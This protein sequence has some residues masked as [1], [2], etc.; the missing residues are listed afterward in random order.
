MS[1]LQNRRPQN[2]KWNAKIFLAEKICLLW[3]R[4]WLDPA[5]FGPFV[6]IL[7]F[8]CLSK[9]RQKS[10]MKTWTRNKNERSWESWIA[11]NNMIKKKRIHYVSAMNLV[12]GKKLKMIK[13]HRIYFC[14]E[15]ILGPTFKIKFMSVIFGIICWPD[16]PDVSP[17]FWSID[18][19]DYIN[20][21]MKLKS[22]Q[23]K[24]LIWKIFL[25]WTL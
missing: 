21:R 9:Y 1:N 18:E 5:Q 25:F 6:L 23:K 17:K 12:I 20:S 2:K 7:I 8:Y 15:C 4:S 16:E 24:S 13:C 11:F 10:T 19:N 14:R 3:S 22:A